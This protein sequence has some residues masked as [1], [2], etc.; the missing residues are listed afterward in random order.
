M[1]G[2]DVLPEKDLL[3]KATAIKIFEYLSL[4]KEV[5]AQA[6]IA[7]KKKQYQKLNDICEFDKVTKKEN[8]TLKKYNRLNLIC[9]SKYSFREY[10]II[11][12]FS[13]LSYKPK[14]PILLSLYN[15]LNKSNNLNLQKESTKEKKRLCMIILQSYTMCI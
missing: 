15:D 4:A 11:K 6:N 12:N 13:S 9:N 1:T 14:Y 7:K 3:E 5:E 8:P 2:K 10:Y